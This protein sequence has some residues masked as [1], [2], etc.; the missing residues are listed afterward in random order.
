MVADALEHRVLGICEW[1]VVEG[2]KTRWEKGSLVLI[3]K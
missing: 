3:N 1:K 2:E